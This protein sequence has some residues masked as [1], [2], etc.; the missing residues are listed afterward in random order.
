MSCRHKLEKEE[1]EPS[2]LK[3]QA[4]VFSYFILLFPV[5]FKVVHLGESVEIIV[6]APLWNREQSLYL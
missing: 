1:G 6:K 4:W 2:Y 5:D 3:K